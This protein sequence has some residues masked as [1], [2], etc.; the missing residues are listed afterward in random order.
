MAFRTHHTFTCGDTFQSRYFHLSKRLS[1]IA[2][3]VDGLDGGAQQGIVIICRGVLFLVTLSFAPNGTH[4]DL[5]FL[6]A[7]ARMDGYTVC[8]DLLWNGFEDLGLRG[9]DRFNDRV[10]KTIIVVFC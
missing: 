8:G 4:F 2:L 6:S 5:G 3:S 9:K 10:Q 1:F 7:G